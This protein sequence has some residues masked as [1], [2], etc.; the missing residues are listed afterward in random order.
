MNYSRFL[1]F[2]LWANS[3]LLAM[4]RKCPAA[5]PQAHVLFAHMLAAEHV[6]LCRLQNRAPDIAIWP[7]IGLDECE[8]LI[9]MNFAGYKDYLKSLGPKDWE[10]IIAYRTSKGDDYKTPVSDILFHVMNHGTYHRGQVMNAIK[11]SGGEVIDTDYIT[12]VRESH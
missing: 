2:V 6:W 1:N 12:F 7:E 4:L 8:R 5:D 10:S 3:R 11:R 9:E